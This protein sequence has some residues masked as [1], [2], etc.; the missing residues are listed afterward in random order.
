MRV[1]LL[2]MLSLFSNITS[3]PIMKTNNKHLTVYKPKIDTIHEINTKRDKETNCVVFFTGGSN[4]IPPHIYSDFIDTFTKKNISVYIPCFRHKHMKCLLNVLHN[5]YK[6]V[7]L[8]GHSSGC[9]TL[10][11]HCKEEFIE[12]IILIDPVNTNILNPNKYFVL[13]FVKKLMFIHAQKSY[14]INRDPFGL[15]F[16]PFLK[17]RQDRIYGKQLN[18]ILKLTYHEYGHSDILNPVY[19][20]IMHFTR[21]TVG[22]KKRTES[23]LLMYHEQ[24]VSR[25]KQ[26]IDHEEI[27]YTTSHLQNR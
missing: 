15:P 10:L 2:Y 8:I 22:N 20:N 19:S 17:I 4:A 21:I 27:H 23:N 14:K 18:R 11:N 24:V 16:I 25:I 9:T 26:F 12:R 5:K 7:V 3:F 13:P 6:Q 1:F